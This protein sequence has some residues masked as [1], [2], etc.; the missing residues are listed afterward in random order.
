MIDFDKITKE[1]FYNEEIEKGVGVYRNYNNPW[2]FSECLYR[3][4]KKIPNKFVRFYI[5][6]SYLVD[7]WIHKN[8]I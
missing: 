1:Y 2:G 4:F 7:I 3:Y 6:K 8:R 5:L